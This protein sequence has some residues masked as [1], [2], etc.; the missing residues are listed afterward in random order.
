MTVCILAGRGGV[1]KTSQ[2]KA[3]ATMSN[4]FKWA[5]MELKDQHL[6]KKYTTMDI[7]VA[8]DDQYRI[9]PVKTLN[10]FSAW[11]NTIIRS[12][13]LDCVVVDGI[14]DLRNYAMDEWLIN[15]NEQRMADGKRQRKTIGGDNLSAWSAINDRVRSLL[16]PLI[17]YGINTG[18]NVIFTAEMKPIYRKNEVIGIEPNIKEWIEY[19]CEAI[20]VLNK[21]GDK[22]WVDSIKT[23]LWSHGTF[24]ETV[25]KDTGV[26]RVMLQHGLL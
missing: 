8:I 9:D 16:E 6:Q 22:F 15:E 23:P 14:S 21:D 4:K 11:K 10:N 20:M 2:T 25:E 26:L 17:N 3:I 19:P 1:G 5:I 13:S 24:S 18:T 12:N 7:I